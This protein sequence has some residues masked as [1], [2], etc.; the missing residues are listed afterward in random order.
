MCKKAQDFVADH[1]EPITQN[2][3]QQIV[4]AV[5]W[6]RRL[7]ASPSLRTSGFIRRLLCLGCVVD[8]VVLRCVCVCVCVCVFCEYLGFL[9]Q[10]HSIKLHIYP[11]PMPF[12]LIV[13]SVVKQNKT[14]N[15]RIT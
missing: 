12:N 5:P 8:T 14:G 9:Y 3:I 7:V 1:T 11:S 2:Q 10:H 6:L 13:E 4:M 15:V